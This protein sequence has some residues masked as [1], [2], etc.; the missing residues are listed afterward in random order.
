MLVCVLRVRARACV[1]ACVRACFFFFLRVCACF[2][3]VDF[4]TRSFR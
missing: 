1:R 4:I 3:H 2:V